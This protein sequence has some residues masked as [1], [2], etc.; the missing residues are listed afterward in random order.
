MAIL[1]QLASRQGTLTAEPNKEVARQC[2]ENPALLEELCP[3]LQSRDKRLQGDVAEVFTETARLNPDLVLPYV[4]DLLILLATKNNRALWEM[5]AGLALVAGRV[6]DRVYPHAEQLFHL[7]RTG[8][9]IVV[10]GAIQT[11]AQVATAQAGYAPAILPGLLERLEACI[12][13]DMPRLGEYILPA[14]LANPGYRPQMAALL[15][16]RLPE[17]NKSGQARVRRLLQQMKT[18]RKEE[19]HG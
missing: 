6:P 2:A 19:N 18:I 14:V 9:V 4:D 15:E 1:D 3:H 13:R 11:L 8:S 7:A 10:D 17:G 16:R 5:L 12:P